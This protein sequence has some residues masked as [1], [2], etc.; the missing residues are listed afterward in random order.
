[1]RIR[2]GTAGL[3]LVAALAGCTSSDDAPDARPATATPTGYVLPDGWRWESY[4]D[5]EVGVPGTWKYTGSSRV[6]ENCALDPKAK[7][8]VG[9]PRDTASLV[10]CIGPTPKVDPGSLVAKAGSFVAFVP[11]THAV[12]EGGD[13]IVRIPDTVTQVVIQ[14]EPALREQISATVHRLIDADHNGC[15]VHHPIADDPA[16]RPAPADV[17]TLTDV[18]ALRACRYTGL[19]PAPGAG[20]TLSLFSSLRLE[21]SVARAV[22][23]RI[24]TAPEGSGPNK[25]GS[26]ADPYGDEWMV[27]QALRGDTVVGEI[28]VRYYGCEH[29]GFDDGV[30]LRRLTSD[31]VTPIFAQPNKP[32]G[33][34]GTSAMRAVM[35]RSKG[36]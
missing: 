16:W 4:R 14:A 8:A 9:R 28:V 10:G 15:A 21:G 23:A 36:N 17:A 35:G 12:L 32:T 27:L 24:A 31:A 5:V 19:D 26:C 11:G 2:G 22:L 18:D 33:Y 29:N 20:P 1:M 3:V 34:I 13:R 25:P 7:P 6:S 30:A